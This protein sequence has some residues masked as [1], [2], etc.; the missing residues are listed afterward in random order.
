MLNKKDTFEQLFRHMADP[1]LLLKD[2]V[3]IDFNGAAL[4]FLGYQDRAALLLKSPVDVAPATQSN[5]QATTQ[6]TAEAFATTMK[7]GSHRFSA[8][9]QKS[10]G[11]TLFTEVVLTAIP[12]ENETLVCAMWRDI[13]AYLASEAAL[14]ES[15]K[16]LQDLRE[17]SMDAWMLV[18]ESGFLDCNAAALKVFGC[19][20]KDLF[21][22]LHPNTLSPET[23]PDGSSST[24]G[25]KHHMSEAFR[26][27]SHQ[28]EWVHKRLDT[29]QP[30]YS[31][32]FLSTTSIK[33]KKVIQASVRDISGRKH[34]EDQIRQLATQDPLTGLVNRYVLSERI[35]HAVKVNQRSK[36]FGALLFIDLDQF[37]IINDTQGHQAGDALLQQVAER[38]PSCVR[39]SDTVARFGGDEFAILLEELSTNE[40]TA[41]AHAEFVGEKIVRAL[42]RPYLINK[43]EQTN[44]PSIGVALFSPESDADD[45]LQQADIAMYQAKRSGRNT[46]RFFDPAM[47]KSID[48][49]VALEKDLKRAL[50]DNEFEL[51]YQLQVNHKQTP[52][53]AEALLRWKHPTLGYIPPLDY[54]SI[55][56]ESGLIVPIGHWVLETACKQL[57]TWGN[58]PKTDQLVMAINVSA[59]QFNETSFVG[60]I[61]KAIK[62]YRIKPHL[63]KLELT[64]SMLVEN[65]ETIIIKMTQLKDLG[66]S[67]SLD[68]F[69]TGYS[70]LQYLKKLPLDQLKI[71][72]SFV[73]DLE[74]DEQDRSIVQTI[75]A[76]AKGLQMEVIAE[77]VETQAQHQ[78]LNDYGCLNYQG[79]LF[80]RPLVISE[81]D[82][83]IA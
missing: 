20:N 67:F 11:S 5:G 38:L 15:K 2:G 14:L 51:H 31:D 55:A 54:I 30:F 27:Q 47:Q 77:G 4:A 68:D 73:R 16:S 79:Y 33:G 46:I 42:N 72:Q 19:D 64:E 69:G 65:L 44:T 52:L 26:N 41:V 7:N 8:E 1:A 56:E 24:E 62:K 48:L 29:D 17:T 60:S 78:M 13:S 61:F 59:V 49:R 36:K 71:D 9:H 35:Q 63:L 40:L 37:K 76:M 23:Q 80:A 22:S 58:N 25:I 21:C 6:L 39:E 50:H 43:R 70:S 34:N 3:F 74:T 57:E 82:D 81:F 83:L 18:D 12:I 53:G 10:D 45:I 28:F 66:V 32:I 75:I